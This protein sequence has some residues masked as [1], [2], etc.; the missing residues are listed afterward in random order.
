MAASGEP[1]ARSSGR[2]HN[3]PG[4]REPA[5]PNDNDNDND[6]DDDDDDDDDDDEDVVGYVRRKMPEKIRFWAWQE[7]PLAT[8]GNG[9]T[10]RYRP[11]EF[12]TLSDKIFFLEPLRAFLLRRLTLK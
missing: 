5:F 7:P 2:N 10:T 3:L 1:L 6:N 11:F 12:P 9:L 4:T 8:F